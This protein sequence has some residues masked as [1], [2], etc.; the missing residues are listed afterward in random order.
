MPQSGRAKSSPSDSRDDDIE[1]EHDEKYSRATGTIGT[2]STSVRTRSVHSLDAL[3]PITDGNHGSGISQYNSSELGGNRQV[4]C[5][6]DQISTSVAY[7][8]V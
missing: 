6:D 4:W 3:D 7:S 8:F 5:G 1:A 2:S